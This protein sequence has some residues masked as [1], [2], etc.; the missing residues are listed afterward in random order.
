MP[1]GFGFGRYTVAGGILGVFYESYKKLPEPYTQD[2]DEFGD[3]LTFFIK[4]W[5]NDN[6]TH[7]K[8]PKYVT[9]EEL[10]V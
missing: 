9:N 10:V 2:Y 1:F 5:L 6:Y 4:E 8:N 3:N 7:I